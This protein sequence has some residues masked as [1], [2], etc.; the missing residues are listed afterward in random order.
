M[1]TL[2]RRIAWRAEVALHPV[3]THIFAPAEPII[4]F[5]FDD[6]PLTALEEGGRQLEAAGVGGT[7]Y[8]AFGRAGS[9]T[10][11]GLIG[12]PAQ[13]ASCAA[14]GH[15]LACHTFSHPDCRSLLPRALEED[16]AR[17]RQAA[18]AAGAP[19]TRNLAWPY[20]SHNRPAMS[21]CARQGLRSAR[22]GRVG[23]IRGRADLFSL[24][25]VPIYSSDGMPA[26]LNAIDEAARRPAWL[27]LYTHD[28]RE[29]PSDVGCTPSEFE[30]V[31]RHAL[32]SGGVLEPVDAALDRLKAP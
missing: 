10:D 14:R 22:G 6:F 32:E 23:V 24:P 29:S 18:R 30:H 15:E 13:L 7:F 27:I 4:S 16:I 3:R 28:V 8:A 26:C 19:A 11:A 5:T 9:E 31:L 2:A 21:A 17:N 25:G 1:T 12:S 20:G